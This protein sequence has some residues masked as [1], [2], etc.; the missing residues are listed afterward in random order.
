[1]LKNQFLWKLYRS[2]KGSVSSSIWDL[3]NQYLELFTDSPASL[4][5][6][7]VLE[8]AE[9]IMKGSNAW[10]FYEFFKKWNPKKLR[11]TD[12]EEVKD[13]NGEIYKPLAIKVL[14]RAKESIENLSDEQIGNI[15]W[16]IN[17]YDIAIKKYPN[18]DWNIRSKALL[19]LRAGQQVEAKNIYK[20]LCQKMGEKYYIWSEFADCWQETDIKIAL[21]CK[22]ISLENNEDF[23][24]KIRLELARQ[25]IK[26]KKYE[27]AIVEI[28]LYKKHYT[29]MGWY[30]EAVSK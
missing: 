16:L 7:K 6:S 11:A 12:W 30:I 2:T 19:Y 26:S 5:D 23:I 29:E 22:A 24:G 13:D 21:L 1:M 20:M 18:D 25:L 10:R 28:C 3:F 9:R 14:K 8:L 27:N 17:L 4:F 15:Q